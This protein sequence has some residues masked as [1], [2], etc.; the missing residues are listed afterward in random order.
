MDGR[1][2]NLRKIRIALIGNPNTGKTSLFNLLTDSSQAT[3]NWGGVTVEKKFNEFFYH[4]YEIEVIDL[5]GLYDISTSHNGTRE[6][7]TL[8]RLIIKEGFD[9]IINVIDSVNLERNLYLTLQL[10]DV[11]APM[12]VALNFGDKVDEEHTSEIADRI[13]KDLGVPTLVISTK[14]ATGIEELKKTIIG[15]EN[16]PRPNAY[17]MLI[18]NAITEI[19]K[20]IA[21]PKLRYFLALKGL[22]EKE[23][24]DLFI[25][26]LIFYPSEDLGHS[27][28]EG[29]QDSIEELTAS[30]RLERVKRIM[31]QKG[32]KNGGK[33]DSILDKLAFGKITG[34]IIFMAMMFLM[35]TFSINV[36]GLFQDPIELLSRAIFIDFSSYIMHLINAPQ[37]LNFLISSGI[38]GGV[39]TVV[40]FIPVIAG[41]FL[42]LSFL[43][44]SGYLSRAAVLVDGLLKKIGLPGTAFVPLIVSFGC[45]VP[46]I[47][48][49]RALESKEA[50]IKT[51][52]MAPFMSCS[53]RLAVY[54]LFC[55]AFFKENA[56]IIVF[57]LYILGIVLAIFT[58][59]MLNL[60]VGKAPSSALV[61]E[62]P[63]YQLPS[64][65]HLLKKTLHRVNS[66]VFGA[67]RTIVI[68][69]V[70]VQALGGL[71]REGYIGS[72]SSNQ[73]L[74][75]E[76]G[77]STI[78]LFKPMGLH[79]EQW[80]LA[81]GLITGILAKE[82]VIGTLS[83]IYNQENMFH[84]PD[85][86]DLSYTRNSL[87]DSWYTLK[88]N[89]HEFTLLKNFFELSEYEFENTRADS[90]ANAN[91]LVNKLKA[92]VHDTKA[93]IAYLIFILLYFPCIAVFGAIKH[94]IGTKWALFS[95][96]W[97]TGIAYVVAVAFYQI[98]ITF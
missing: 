20:Y 41:L 35:F 39:T 61:L 68:I 8:T 81:V 63:R 64:L 50:Q 44:E 23:S 91:S 27:I 7:R 3:G 31:P 49:T 92:N 59:F 32:A 58:G 38:G 73:S 85:K 78:T 2:M 46:A 14:K 83:A 19:S 13:T 74:I 22:E 42:F 54:S 62:L 16:L 51:A 1:A 97:S 36:G 96:V 18:D 4:D 43:E 53:A 69:F 57:S 12:I 67:G 37:I 52:L 55:A 28:E 86:A 76:V 71:S 88:R 34:S 60:F 40:A 72:G 5:P 89:I 95:A 25:D 75:T 48:A 11:R 33:I 26:H 6:Q 21:N 45:N 84:H 30:T 87:S 80:P 9:L 70:I 17:P 98:A 10:V 77:K 82:V 90:E 47:I 79:E 15:P 94:E 24:G 65:R 29:Y 66:F 56:A 93:V